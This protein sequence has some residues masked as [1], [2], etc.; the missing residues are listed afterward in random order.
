MCKR[1]CLQPKIP[2]LRGYISQNALVEYIMTLS[3]FRTHLI[4]T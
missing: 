1:K 4:E 2:W 3:E